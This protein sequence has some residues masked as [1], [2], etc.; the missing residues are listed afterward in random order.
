MI[1]LFRLTS[2]RLIFIYTILLVISICLITFYLYWSTAR[3]LQNKLKKNGL[4]WE[5]SKAFDGSALIGKWLNK[6][7]IKD[8]K[9]INFNLEKNG[10]IVQEGITSKMLW[11]IDEL[12]SEISKYFTLKIGDIIFTGT[13]SGVGR[14]EENDILIGR[15]NQKE[16]FSIKI[17]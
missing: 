2:F 6:S 14:V 3:D 4:P 16:C 1:N 9:S 8:L 7:E 10:K 15:I 12:I 11:N 5:K 13:P 17:K